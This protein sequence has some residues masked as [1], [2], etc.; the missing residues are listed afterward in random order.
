MPA[1]LARNRSL[2]EVPNDLTYFVHDEDRLVV[3]PHSGGRCL[4]GPREFAVLTALARPGADGGPAPLPETVETERTLAKLI[5]NWVV[6][7]NGNRPEIRIQEAPLRTAYYAITDGC[8]LRCPYCYA[9]SE[10]CLPGELN[11]EE[12]L[13]L[14]SQIADFGADLIVFTG[15]EPMLRKDLFQIAEHANRSG[16]KSNVITNATMIRTPATARRFAELF[17]AVTISLDGGT[18]ESHDRTRGAGS[19][20]RT[21]R[22]IQLLND[23][24]VVPAINHIVTSDNVEELEQFATFVKGLEVHSVR[25]MYHNDLGR[26]VDDEYGFGFEDHL[27][28]QQIVWTSPVAG[29]LKP[30]G[31]R[32]VS[33]CSIKGNCG[34]GGNEIYVNSLG[35]VYPCKL[36]TGRAQYAGN[37]RERPL[38][39][40]FAA[41][42]LSAMRR[43][44]VYGGDYHADC[45]KC[46]IKPSCG[47]GCRAAHMAQSGDLQR[48]SRHWCRI[49]R[50]GVVTQLWREAGFGN[51]EL[52]E[53]D[54]EMTVPRLVRDDEVHP[55]FDDWKGYVPDSPKA[56]KVGEL[57]SIT[58][59]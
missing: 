59:V 24:G 8:N 39:E 21:H 9:S 49:L 5:L 52:A 25:L 17:N 30:D 48:N 33:P 45:A 42:V 3:N 46:Y 58:P 20:A 7:Y 15:G 51:A 34:M 32:I 28:I 6:Y 56:I 23:A 2:F 44:T 16:L 36:I 35:D 29:K 10:K 37:V 50:H 11:T 53:K 31:P 1:M 27:R 47:G 54:L 18:A 26:G 19:F 14:V 40:I 38:A 12:S 22:A 4:L 41:P 43:S 55:V 13:G 57:L